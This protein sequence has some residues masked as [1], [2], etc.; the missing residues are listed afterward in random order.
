MSFCYNC[1]WTAVR[2]IQLAGSDDPDKVAQALRSGNLEWDS[3]W[4]RLRIAPD[5]IGEINGMVA[6][7]QEGGKLV[8]VWPQ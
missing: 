1:F 3:A 2:A 6:Q 4:G 7:V 8:K 5:G